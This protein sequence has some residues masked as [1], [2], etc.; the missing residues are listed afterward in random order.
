VLTPDQIA[1]KWASNL[2]AST[3]NITQA[4]QNVNVAPGQAAARQ[5]TAY[6]NGVNASQDKWARN[7]AGVSLQEWQTAMINKGVPR[8]A[9]GAAEAQGEF[10]QF[11][12]RLLP[13]IANGV[14]TLPPRGSLENNIA[15]AAAMM[16]YM[17][18]FQG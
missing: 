9:S 8:I 14:S 16:R 7:V 17:A 13:Y 4:V 2:S 5:K 10:Q 6:V 15:R 1:Q 18:N 12:T 11:M 3:Q